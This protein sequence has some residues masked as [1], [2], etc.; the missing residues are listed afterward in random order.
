MCVLTLLALTIMF[1]LLIITSKNIKVTS[2]KCASS[3]SSLL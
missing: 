1:Y 3:S 2:E